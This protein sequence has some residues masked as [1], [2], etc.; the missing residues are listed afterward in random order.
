M[1][2]I[3]KIKPIGLTK[4]NNAEYVNFMTRFRGLIPEAG[5]GDEGGEDIL[6]LAA[7]SNPLGITAEQL[8][9]FDTDNALLVDLVNQ[10]R[11]SD[12][13]AQMLNLDSQRDDLVVYITSTAT[14]MAK[15]PI[16]AQR[17][18]AETVR[19]IL[20]P[21]VGIYKSANQQETAQID[22]MLADLAKPG[23]P[24][25]VQKLGLT[26][27]VAALR[28]A[29]TEYATLTAQRTNNKAASIKENSAAVRLRMDALYDDMTTMAFVQS[30][31]APT[32][33]TAAFVNNLNTLIGETSALYNQRIA[34][35]KAAKKK[36]EEDV[37]N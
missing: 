29:N 30:V 10:S 13:T 11:I 7:G 9:A 4:M 24:E 3:N 18:A 5:A 23:I 25:L 33:E 1:G 15:S 22:G 14:Q 32:A 35:A 19:N 36:P 31:A 26:E 37:L 2:I 8:S 6:S 16:T 27:V 12:E 34:A 17:E 21:Y 28:Q 20:K